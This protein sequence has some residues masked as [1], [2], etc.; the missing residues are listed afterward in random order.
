MTSNAEVMNRD[1][2]K[3]ENDF[4]TPSLRDRIINSS[5]DELR[6][7]LWNDDFIN[8]YLWFA[9]QGVEEYFYSLVPTQQTHVLR[10]V[11]YTAEWVSIF[12]Y[13]G[14]QIQLF[15]FE[16]WWDRSKQ[17]DHFIKEY[18]QSATP[19]EQRLYSSLNK[20]LGL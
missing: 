20:L 9:P 18:T 8:E 19:N 15:Q 14:K 17:L 12:D 10:Y 13:E 16:N 4:N 3:I 11:E 1:N 5:T 6:N 7:L 2:D